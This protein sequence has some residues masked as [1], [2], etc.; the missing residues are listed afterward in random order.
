MDPDAGGPRAAGPRAAIDGTPGPTG[1][2]E[3]LAPRLGLLIGALL[4]LAPGSPPRTWVLALIVIVAALGLSLVRPSARAAVLALLAAGVL[5]RSASPGGFSDVLVVTIAAIEAMLAGGSPYG[6]GF[7]VSTPPGAPFAYGP[8]ALVWYLPSLDAPGRME[9]LASFAVLVALAARGRVVGLAVFAT[10][11][12]LLVTAWDGSNDTSAGLL[13]L[14]ALLVAVRAPMAGAVLLALAT[15]FKPYALAWLPGLLAYAGGVGP[16]V[17]FVA[18]SIAAWAPAAWLWGLEAL[19]WSFR[20]ADEIHATP[21]YSLAY[22]V[23]GTIDLPKPA[24]TA[25]RVGAGVATAALGWLL[26]RSARS[27]IL[28]GALVFLVTLYLGWWS[29]FAYVAALA[30]VVCWHLD[31]WLGLGRQRA[32]WPGD[33]AGTLGAAVEA[34]WPVRRPA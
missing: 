29:T 5:A 20:R 27:F 15:A 2:I 17:A 32:T 22:G 13:L 6:D 21:Y 25:I 7:G 31:D 14:V 30:P 4:L 28:A 33:P 24:W 34:R 10:A 1:V 19:A 9:L 12:P 26:V 16:L 11:P 3:H 8:L 23:G 18:A